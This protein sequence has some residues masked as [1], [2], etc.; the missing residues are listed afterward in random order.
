M[1]FFTVSST[2]YF[3]LLIFLLLPCALFHIPF[4]SYAAQ[5]TLAWD[6]SEGTV[7][8]YIMHYGK[9]SG[10]YDYSVNVG[11]FITC[12]ISGLQEGTKYYFAV[13]AYN[14][15]GDSDYS[16]EVAYTTPFDNSIFE[17][18]VSASSDDAEE[19]ATGGMRLTSSDLELVYDKGNQTVGMRFNGVEIPQGAT[20]T[21]AYIQFQ[22][23]EVNTA[24]TNLSIQ[25][26]ASDDPVTFTPSSGNVSSRPRTIAAVSWAPEPWTTK[27]QAGP[28]Q[29]TPD[30]SAIIQEI[31]DRP[32]WTSG[33]SLV[34]IITGTGERTAESYDGTPSAAPLL[35]VEFS[36]GN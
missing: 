4:I 9:A 24:A 36:S 32:G 5:V 25:G 17:V 20:I 31:V 12:I 22:V 1:S 27:G 16:N 3:K 28:D 34:I 30:I 23:D 33:N 15:I 11:N 21:S 7:D 8:G 14:D 2:C 6:P 26:Q 18:Q 35:H 19:K 10:E 29:Q 13:T